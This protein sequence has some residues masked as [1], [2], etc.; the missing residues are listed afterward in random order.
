MTNPWH[1][2][3]IVKYPVGER[4]YFKSKS[5]PE[6]LIKFPPI[7]HIVFQTMV[8]DKFT[9]MINYL[10]I[11]R[12]DKGAEIWHYLIDTI[13]YNSAYPKFVSNYNGY[14]SEKF[15]FKLESLSIIGSWNSTLPN[16]VFA[17]LIIRNLLRAITTTSFSSSWKVLASCLL[18]EL[19]IVNVFVRKHKILKCV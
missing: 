16:T 13:L 8:K 2:S 7:R 10:Q 6:R 1:W 3:C 9:L 19:Q 12:H 15:Y 17:I 4:K 14:N 5:R 11:Q 18:K